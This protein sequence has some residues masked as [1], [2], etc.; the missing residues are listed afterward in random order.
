DLA[1]TGV[2]VGPRATRAVEPFGLVQ[3][4][5]CLDRTHQPH[6]LEGSLHRHGDAGDTR[7]GLLPVFDLEVAF[8]VVGPPVT[9]PHS[10]TSPHARFAEEYPG[11]PPAETGRRLRPDPHRAAPPG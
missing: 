8:V 3:L 1:M 5:Q 2:R 9:V 4:E 6:L 10:I 7:C 11:P